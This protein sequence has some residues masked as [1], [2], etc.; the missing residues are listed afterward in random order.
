MPLRDHFRGEE[1][2]PWKWKSVHS[3]WAAQITA[4]LNGGILPAD[5]IAI[6]TVQLGS[7]AQVDVSAWEEDDGTDAVNDANGAVVTAVWAPPRP[8]VVVA[9]DVADLDVLEIQVRTDAG[10]RLVAAVELV[11]PANK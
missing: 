6:P 2:G 10:Y 4:T 3:Q 7:S 8:I 1:R 5:F 11:S 9:C